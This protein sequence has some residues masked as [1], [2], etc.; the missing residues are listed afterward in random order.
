MARRLEAFAALGHQ[1][2]VI[3]WVPDGQQPSPANLA[4]LAQSAG[5]VELLEIAADPATRL[6]RIWNLRTHPSYIAARIPTPGASAALIEGVTAFAPDLVWVE[7]IHPSWLALEIHRRLE[8][9]LCYRAH[10]IEHRYL[11][12]QARLARSTR[13]KLA[14]WAGTWGLARAENALH[15]AADHVFDISADD[16]A[17]WRDK[18]FTNGQWLAPQPDPDILAQAGGQSRDIDL[19]FVGSLSSPNNIAGLKWFL[20]A[21]YP[22]IVARMNDIR[23]VIAGRKP[24]AD[25]VRRAREIGVE[26]IADPVNAAPLFG[27]A[28][29]MI[30]PILHGSGVNIKTVDM[31]ATGQPVVTTTKGARG[32]PQEIVEQLVVADAPDAFADAAV[33]AVRAGR[34]GK[35]VADRA[36]LIATVFG[37]AAVADALATVLPTGAVH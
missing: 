19:L 12:E 27:R 16:L 1:V 9:P 37:T 5:K 31:F 18:G 17:Y 10:N 34:A 30:N 26:L 22:A 11:S 29:V 14:L 2:L 23:L 4:R 20:D 13:Q 8:I 3:A 36:T 33:S 6:R 15:T 21:I 7:G 25:L 35:V 28:H 32:L 24:P